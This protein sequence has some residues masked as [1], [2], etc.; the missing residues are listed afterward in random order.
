MAMCA[1]LY[2]LTIGSLLVML[3][4]DV[5]Y[6]FSLTIAFF[7]LF[8][9][10]GSS[11]AKKFETTARYS[12][13][14]VEIL[15]CLLGAGAA[16]AI[17]TCAAL[18]HQGL[19][20]ISIALFFIASIGLLTGMELPLLFQMTSELGKARERFGFLLVFDYLG[21]LVG[22]ILFAFLLLPNMDFIGTG[23]YSA[24]FNLIAAVFIF[25]TGKNH[26]PK[27]SRY[28]FGF[29]IMATLVFC[30]TLLFREKP[31]QEFIDFNIF[32]TSD[33]TKIAKTFRTPYQKV[34]VTL[35]PTL[36]VEKK[37]LPNF[38]SI[39]ALGKADQWISIFLNNYIQAHSPFKSDTDFYHH[40][41]VHPAMILAGKT[42]NVLILGGGDGLPAKEVQKYP[43]IKK[44]TN[45]DLDGD[46]VN[47]TRTNSLMR[48]HSHDALNNPLLNLIVADAFRWVR[49]SQ[50]KFDVILVDFPEGID[51][52]L[53]RSYSLEF[54]RDLKRILNDDGVISFQVDFF[55]NPVYWSII[56]TMVEAGFQ[57]IPH[58]TLDP[59]GIYGLVLLSKNTLTLTNYDKKLKQ[60]SF[61]QPAFLVAAP[62]LEYY[63]DEQKIQQNI[64]K[65]KVNTFFNPNFLLYYRTSYPWEISIGNN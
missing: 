40:A 28:V 64:S 47:F 18:S 7:I 27:I 35:T 22:S 2:E 41:F 48:E 12:L 4:G 36:D 43:V 34:T 11:L 8:M 23:L 17:A 26:L 21:S 60:F 42:E 37:E 33:N 61:I 52:P 45:V 51:L 46:W 5:I 57:V 39:E 20:T 13:L 29:A 55:G 63:R 14:I 59:A 19:T 56:K 25:Y 31:L 9:G 30:V 32:K 1:L 54:L 6:Y 65:F 16:P 38:P 62:M 49:E 3:F 58:H 24:L 10:L 53:A 44:I 50:E 15:I